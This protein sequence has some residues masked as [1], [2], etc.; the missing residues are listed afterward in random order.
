MDMAIAMAMA[1]VMV[2]EKDMAI[3]KHKILIVRDLIS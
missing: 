2:T 1:M 3:A